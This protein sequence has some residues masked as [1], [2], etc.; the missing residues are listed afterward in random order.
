[1]AK[2]N[3]VNAWKNCPERPVLSPDIVDVW[4]IP[5]DPEQHNLPGFLELLSD[6]ELQRVDSCASTA[7]YNEFVITRGHLRNI[8]GRI[9]D[10]PPRD[11][12]FEPGNHGKPFLAGRDQRR[13]VSF[14]VSHTQDLALIAVTLHRAVGIDVEKIHPVDHER[15]AHRFFSRAE[16]TALQ[17]IQGT[18]RLSAFFITWVRKEAIVKAIGEGIVL[19]LDEFDVSVC[20]E[21]PPVLQAARWGAGPVGD[22][23]LADIRINDD[24]AACMAVAGKP[25]RLRLWRAS[26]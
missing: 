14:S 22:W 17:Q 19:G 15:L 11:L 10:K 16:Y 2:C 3:M 21:T 24:Y 25:C 26:A 9:L 1:M 4:G 13:G 23:S 18:A 12:V 6:D 7:R 8:I 20:P 5:L